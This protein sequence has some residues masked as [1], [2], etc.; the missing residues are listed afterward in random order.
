MLADLES[1]DKRRAGVEKKAKQGDKE[2]KVA[3]DLIERAMK[4]LYAGKSARL[5]ERSEDEEKARR[6]RCRR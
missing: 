5:V 2:A 4:L 3:L 1:L 6:W